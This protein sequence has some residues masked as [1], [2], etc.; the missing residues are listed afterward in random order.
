[1]EEVQ[2]GGCLEEEPIPKMHG[3]VLVGAAEASNEVVFKG[4]DGSFGCVASV[5]VRRNKLE[6]N[7]LCFHEAFET[8]G[9]FVV[10]FL[11][12]DKWTTV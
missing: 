2:G 11:E 4:L 9:G 8:I 7:R 3:E 5:E 10:Q 6:V 1:M 12:R